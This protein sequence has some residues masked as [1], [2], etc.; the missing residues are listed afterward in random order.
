MGYPYR[1]LQVLLI[2]FAI[3]QRS[4]LDN[5]VGHRMGKLKSYAMLYNP[6]LLLV[7]SKK[8]VRESQSELKE[9]HVSVQDAKTIMTEI[10]AMD[11]VECSALTGEGVQELLDKVA[12]LTLI[13]KGKIKKD[14]DC[15]VL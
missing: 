3:N 4:S 6:V 9:S 7:G 11:Y 10:G 14:K 2:L 15:V 1:E 5:V 8:D 12:E 13:R